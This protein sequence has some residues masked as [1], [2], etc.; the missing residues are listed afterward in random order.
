MALTPI[1]QEISDFWQG[2]GAWHGLYCNNDEHD[3]KAVKLFLDRNIVIP[4]TEPADGEVTERDGY[5]AAGSGPER[6]SSGIASN[7]NWLRNR[8]LN[9]LALADY[10]ENRD[11]ILAAKEEEAIKARDKR[12]DE[13][14]DELAPRLIGMGPNW[15]SNVSV[16]LQRAVDRIIELEGAAK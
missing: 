2:A 9:L 6:V 1:E 7:P 15:Y 4:R 10:I 12:R 5:A 8:A 11:A 14:V 13:L 16:G 3:P